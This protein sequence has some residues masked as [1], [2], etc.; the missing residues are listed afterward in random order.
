MTSYLQKMSDKQINRRGFLAAAAAG[1]TGLVMSGCKGTVEPIPEEDKTF[2]IEDVTVSGKGEWIPAACWFNCG[3]QCAN[4][5]Y[6]VDGIVVRQK[7][8][9]T[10]PVASEAVPSAR[11]YSALIV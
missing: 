7:T 8:D 11:T 9:D 1:A 3:G 4:Y 2:T 10:H 6:V 5:A